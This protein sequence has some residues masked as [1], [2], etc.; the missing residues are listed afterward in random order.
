MIKQTQFISIFSYSLESVRHLLIFFKDLIA[1]SYPWLCLLQSKEVGAEFL[2]FPVVE[3]IT[4]Q[5]PDFLP[6]V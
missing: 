5:D 6:K 2:R 3:I 1:K 4:C